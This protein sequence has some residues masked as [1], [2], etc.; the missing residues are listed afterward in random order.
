MNNSI[1]VYMAGPYSADNV[2][3]VLENIRRG[4]FAAYR[5]LKAGLA[6]FC[7]WLDYQFS[8]VGHVSLDEYKKYSIAWLEASD[9]V[10]VLSNWEKSSGTKAEI[11]RA[12]QLGI[13]VFFKE[14]DLFQWARR[15]RMKEER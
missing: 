5:L 7:P 4:Q 1:R 14:D 11:T 3:D 13:P 8:L 12:E 10:L 9:A 2:I 15:Y 6:P